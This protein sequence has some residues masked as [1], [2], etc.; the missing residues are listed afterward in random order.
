METTKMITKMTGQTVIAMPS[1]ALSLFGTTGC[2]SAASLLRGVVVLAD[3]GRGLDAT[4]VSVVV[5]GLGNTGATSVETGL[6]RDWATFGGGRELRSERPIEAPKAAV[7]AAKHGDYA[8]VIGAGEPQKQNQ[9]LINQA[10]A[11]FIG[12]MAVRMRAF[13]GPEPWRERT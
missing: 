10:K 13:R 8:Q 11:A 6:S 12:A 4:G 7:A 9:Q 3:N 2:S 1:G 5:S